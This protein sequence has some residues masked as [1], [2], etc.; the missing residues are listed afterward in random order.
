MKTNAIQKPATIKQ[1]AYIDR[2]QK[3][4]GD[5]LPD[6][7]DEISRSEASGIIRELIVKTR[8]NGS[9][10]NEVRINEPRLG[11]AMK[12]CFRLWTGLGRDIWQEKRKSFI[13]EAINTYNL[14]T[15]IAEKLKT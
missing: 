5:D 10:N 9:L 13:E 7:K 6:V 2:L 8:Q 1:M 11:M 3:E 12:E 14:F 15:E 4:I